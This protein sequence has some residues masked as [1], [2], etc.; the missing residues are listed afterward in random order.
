MFACISED[1]DLDFGQFNY[2]K[3]PLEATGFRCLDLP[4]G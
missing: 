1:G 4:F 3:H 2:N